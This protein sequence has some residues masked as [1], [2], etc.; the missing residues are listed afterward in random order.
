MVKTVTFVA[1][2]RIWCTISLMKPQLRAIRE[3]A[4]SQPFGELKVWQAGTVG[5]VTLL[6]G[7]GLQA[8]YG[9]K[10]HEA[11]GSSE[12]PSAAERI[13]SRII[14][15]RPLKVLNAEIVTPI[16]DS[17]TLGTLQ[18]VN[19]PI[20]VPRTNRPFRGVF[21]ADDY[22][23]FSVRQDE[24]GN[25]VA[26]EILDVTLAPETL[27]EFAGQD[28]YPGE[29]GYRTGLINGEYITPQDGVA[30]GDEAIAIPA[31]R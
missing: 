21:N 20:V 27:D 2:S 18:T 15:G 12:V 23:I 24:E 8:T 22:R 4:N 26:H 16:E 25:P 17:G 14:A 7:F 1:N 31:G 28:I 30:V 19:L 9:G 10:Q 29:L 11:T 5:V 13:E 3:I 6:C